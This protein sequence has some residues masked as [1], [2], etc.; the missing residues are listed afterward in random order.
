VTAAPVGKFQRALLPLLVPIGDLTPDSENARIHGDE[1]MEAIRTSLATFSQV[2]PVV[3][4]RRG[5][6][7]VVIKGNGTFRAACELGWSHIAATE[8][9]GSEV[10]AR[11]YAIADNRTAELAE[12]DTVR[13]TFQVDA[14]ASQWDP[15]VSA[16]EWTPSVVG[17]STEALKEAAPRKVKEPA[18]APVPE[19]VDA[20]FVEVVETSIKPGDVYELAGPSGI[21][22]RVMC[23]DSTKPEDV[24]VLMG[25]EK[26]TLLHA[27]PPYGLGKTEVDND[28][29]HSSKLDAFQVSWWKACA[30]RVKDN[31]SAY[32]WGT[33]A[34][35]WRL[36]YRHLDPS[37]YSEDGNAPAT[38]SRPLSIRNE[39]V[40]EKGSQPGMSSDEMRCFA[41]NTE[42]ALFLML[43]EQE[44]SIN[45]DQ[46]WEG[47]EPLRSALKDE[48]DKAGWTDKEV[49]KHAGVTGRMASHWFG[50]SQWNMI[51]EPRYL[52]LQEAGR[53][54]DAFQY[55]YDA[56]R[57][58]YEELKKRY[59]VEIAGAFYESRA[60]F[61]NVHEN[62][63]EVWS[64]PRVVGEERFEHATPKPVLM[65]ARAI[66]SSCP[67]GAI[68][69]E[70][71]AGSGSTLIAAEET[72]RRCFTMELQPKYVDT[73]IR[74]WE[75]KTGA[76][77]VLVRQGAAT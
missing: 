23:G 74:R 18:A 43:G 56:I 46:Y 47:F 49:A 19:A 1:N 48:Q 32:I 42:R 38:L 41:P 4:W 53:E 2:T 9:E 7:R 51:P 61:D 11:A 20:E 29:L 71:F 72:G 8:F 69:L 73:T 3:F 60:F 24:D 57:G 54:F 40:W 68:V 58:V 13:L 12:W 77:A 59:N 14:I 21:T 36:W 39:I 67:A 26:A 45:A 15:G 76:K 33:A 65:I 31:G 34:D 66:K 44:I 62:M 5:A 50:K 10:Y 64:F 22:H 75:A 17:W 6:E 37:L 25:S 52:K 35:L 70:P 28:C 16:V 30:D 27:D 63:T 55:P